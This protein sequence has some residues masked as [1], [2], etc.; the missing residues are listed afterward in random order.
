MRCHEEPG[1]HLERGRPRPQ[2]RHL[3]PH[4][5]RHAFAFRLSEASGHNRAE[6]ERRLGHAN[7]RYLCLYTDPPDDIYP[8]C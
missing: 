6:L 5:A 1:P 8:G 3:R 2:T 7:D 4:D